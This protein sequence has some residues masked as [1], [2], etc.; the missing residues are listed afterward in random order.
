LGISL[1][2]RTS[3]EYG[4]TNKPN[5]ILSYS[6]DE[7]P[8]NIISKTIKPGSSNSDMYIYYISGSDFYNEF[9][10]K[11]KDK[12]S[13]TLTFEIKNDF[14]DSFTENFIL[15]ID[16]TER[17]IPYKNLN[18]YPGLISSNS[19]DKYPALN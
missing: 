17:A 13:I 14:G 16:H 19:S 7:D 10:L 15:P 1:V 4:L 2:G 18:L 11:A 8:E 6:S 9:Y 12:S 5:L 3:R